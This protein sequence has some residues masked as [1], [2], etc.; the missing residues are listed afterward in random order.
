[1]KKRVVVAMSGGV[2]SS[3]AACLLAEQGYEVIGLTM[4]T[5]PASSIQNSG[6]KLRGCCGIDAARDAFS[7]CS[8]LGIPHY[9][10]NFQE[11]FQK[12]VI[13]NFTQE[14]L[15]GR[16]PNPC[17]R[18][19]EFIKFKALLEKS[20]SLQA[21]FLATGHYARTAYNPA[22]NR[23]CL[24]KGKDQKKDQS[25]V[26]Y[27]LKQQ[28]LEKTIFPLGDWTKEEVRAYAR[29]KNLPTAKK[30]DSYDLCFVPDGNY[31]E[32][33]QRETT[34]RIAPGEILN[35]KGETLGNHKGIPFYTIG[36]R[37]G[38]GISSKEPIFVLSMDLE[39]NTLVVGREQELYHDTLSAENI[40]WI[41]TS[42]PDKPI[43][44]SAK[45]RYHATEEEV[46]ITPLSEGSCTVSF[47]KPQKAI[48]PGQAIV[49]Y[50]RDEVL[51]GGTIKMSDRK[52]PARTLTNT[53]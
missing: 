28:E 50:E 13:D 24:S 1:M 15:S 46:L 4:Q 26:L 47:N 8:L 31:E 9:V 33:I 18:C 45:I 49:F 23:Y 53:T 51:G 40:N 6:G 3:V 36:Q 20:L 34:A 12:Q 17:V 11:V 43:K 7:V 39:T 25:Y 2:D 10:L 22:K 29:E 5:W 14:Y 30:S 32:F 41:S 38:L 48:T 21:D 19:N 37:K 44:A 16:T 35:Q 52:D 27:P 42:P